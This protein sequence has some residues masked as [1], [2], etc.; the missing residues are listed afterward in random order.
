MDHSD[1]IAQQIRFGDE[2]AFEQV[3]RANYAGMCGYAMKY[4]EEIEQAEEVVQEVFLNYWDKRATL[5]VTGSLEAYLYRAVRNSCLN[6]L[7]HQKVKR[8]YALVQTEV[9]KAEENQ[10]QDKVIELELQQRIDDCIAQLPPERRKIFKLSREEGLKYKEIAD[11]LGLSVKTVEAQMGKALKFLRE[12]L[13][14]YLPVLIMLA[15]AKTMVL[16]WI[17]YLFL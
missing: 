6:Y 8:Q 15:Y 14:E 11:E 16:Q 9:L 2:Q 12:H 1:N 4:I 5:D 10:S 17:T 13:M 3:F 7:K